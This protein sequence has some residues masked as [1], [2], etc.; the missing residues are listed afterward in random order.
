MLEEQLGTVF[1]CISKNALFYVCMLTS[2]FSQNI[3]ERKESNTNSMLSMA[4]VA[5]QCD[6]NFP[7]TTRN[8]TVIDTSFILGM[9]TC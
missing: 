6:F 3:S 7:P 2:H 1:K 4:S 5:F 9:R 8:Y